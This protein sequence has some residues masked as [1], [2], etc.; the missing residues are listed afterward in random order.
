MNY[1]KVTVHHLVR[2]WDIAGLQKLP[3]LL[4]PKCICPFPQKLTTLLACNTID[5]FCLFVNFTMSKIIECTFFL[6]AA[7]LRYNLHTI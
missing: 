7:L 3:L 4:P 6:K 1:P 5:S 2:K